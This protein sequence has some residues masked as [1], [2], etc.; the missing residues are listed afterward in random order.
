MILTWNQIVNLLGDIDV[1]GAIAAG[2]DADARGDVVIP[3][4]GEMTFKDPPGDVHIKYG[5]IEGGSHYVVKIASG[6]YDNPELGIS[7]SQ[8]L[9]LLFEQKTGELAVVL[10]DEGNLTDIRTAAAG[11]VAAK[12]LAP[13]AIGKIGIVGTGIQ[14]R[15][16]AQYLRCVTD[17]RTVV[18]W[19]R[20]TDHRNACTADIAELGFDTSTV[21]SVEEL[22]AHCNLIVTT[23]PAKEPLIRSEWIAP[24]THI[25]AIGSD[26]PGKQELDAEV[27][28]GADL[29]VADR[30]SQC[31]QRGEIASALASGNFDE[32]R[33]IE[34]GDIVGG[35]TAGRSNDDQI[36]VA[37][38]TG[39]AI[40]DLQIAL[41]V[42]KVARAIDHI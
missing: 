30:L 35:R 34:L 9:M 10:L 27:L 42:Y 3:P 6:F 4:V 36:T 7:S 15:K 11:A 22:C 2:F 41:A 33:V 20:N 23:T 19:G 21:E 14:A 26:T 13:S 12:F 29:V 37:D 40:Q 18:V 28:L 17:S 8:G 25:T 39:V 1:V 5:Y 16:Q 32:S 38:L 24:G 31:R